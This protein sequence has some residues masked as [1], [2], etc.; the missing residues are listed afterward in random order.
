MTRTHALLTIVVAMLMIPLSGC[1][2]DGVNGVDGSQ[3]E[4]GQQ[5]EAGADGLDGVNGTD[6][7]NGLNGTD[8]VDGINGVNGTNGTD[9]TDG[10]TTLIQT[11]VD[12]PGEGC[13]D[14]GVG[15]HVG[16]DDDNDGYLSIDEVD[17]T[18]YVCNGADG[19]DGADGLF[20]DAGIDLIEDLPC[21]V[22]PDHRGE[23]VVRVVE[24]EP[25]L[26]LLRLTTRR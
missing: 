15:L 20:T 9:G 3:G 17:E 11:F 26:G 14:G 25:Q 10:K 18:V 24:R 8:G 2:S 23:V 16:I 22:L 12:Y 4:Q 19:Q 5:G 13:V 1:V 21:G 7:I 6:G